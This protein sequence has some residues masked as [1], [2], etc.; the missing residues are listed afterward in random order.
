MIR[1]LDWQN[2]TTFLEYKESV[3]S[4]SSDILRLLSKEKAPVFNTETLFIN[5][6]QHP[7]Q[8]PI[9]FFKKT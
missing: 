4:E 6:K 3:N 9:I 1:N 8:P 5:L 7:S 2:N